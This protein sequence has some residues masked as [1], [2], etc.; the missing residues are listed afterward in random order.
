MARLKSCPFTFRGLIL[1][2][3]QIQAQGLKPVGFGVE[4]ARLK[5][6]ALLLRSAGA[7]AQLVWSLDGT[8]EVVT[9]HFPWPDLQVRQIR[10]Q[11]L[12]PGFSGGLMA[13]LKSCPFTLP[14]PDLEVRQI[15]VRPK[16]QLWRRAFYRAKTIERTFRDRR[17]S[18]SEDQ[19]LVAVRVRAGGF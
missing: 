8:T 10:A 17:P 9:L 5:S 11:G 19:K 18:E 15:L 1:E 2:V 6:R 14:W 12:K 13:R 3:R 4:T 16:W 7:E